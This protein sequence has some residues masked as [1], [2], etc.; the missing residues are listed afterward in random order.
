MA[1]KVAIDAGLVTSGQIQDASISDSS[2]TQHEGA[3]EPLLELNKMGVSG[4][5]DLGDFLVTTSADPT[6]P[7]HFSRKGYVDA[8]VAEASSSA[9][10]E[11]ARALAAE[12][13]LQAAIDAEAATAR[14]AEQA[15][16]TAIAGYQTSN[17][18][19]LAA[20]VAALGVERARI[21]AILEAAGADS[22]S[23][24]DIV[25]LINSVDTENDNA[26]ASY[27]L[28]NNQA[29]ADA[30][31]AYQAADS[32]EEAARIA[33]DGAEASARAAADTALAGD[34]AAE[35][36]TARAAEQAN[37]TALA[38][39][40]TSN[41]AALATEQAARIAGDDGLAAS[42]ASSVTDLED[43]D[44]AIMA[45]VAAEAQAR[46]TAITAVQG[47]LASEVSDLEDADAQNLAQVI[48][49]IQNT[50]AVLEAADAALAT[51]IEAEETA[52]VA[53]DSAL[54]ADYDSKIQA[55]AASRLAYQTANDAAVGVERGRIDAILD[56]A[57][58][59]ADS[60]TDIVALINQVDTENDTAFGSYVT[61]N[62]AALAQAIAD[63]Q[64][65]D[66]AEA[67]ARIAGDAT[68]QADLDAWKGSHVIGT[69]TQA[70]SAS[71]DAMAQG[72]F[73]SQAM[74]LRFQEVGAGETLGMDGTSYFVFAHPGATVTLPAGA[75]A[76][77][78]V[79]IK[80]GPGGGDVTITG[81]TIDG[82]N[83]MVMSFDWGAVC[84][85]YNGSDW[86]VG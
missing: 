65:A 45:A 7:G 64:G 38:G 33:A 54:A 35:A 40:Q 42:L 43:A 27:V 22:D 82:A 4:L 55:E 76:G 16:A 3:L 59:D 9:A 32:T 53:A 84:L 48:G 70:H 15:N 69:D 62:N 12:A 60:F 30:I 5:V 49:L 41:D 58:A 1:Y 50:T 74:K 29:L 61:S 79:E 47:A 8:R 63:F 37:A 31:A 77:R 44:D 26:L 73:S 28:S 11:E 52:R 2:V 13:V 71:L 68:V 75:V 18:A 39:Y 23:F 57:G 20:D 83:G 34:I 21:D 66:N 80:R 14:A 67:A 17:D 36:A 51:D 72:D 85:T 24:A 6:Q 86:L 78:R 19:A 56:A 10:A 25:A 81:G 46:Q